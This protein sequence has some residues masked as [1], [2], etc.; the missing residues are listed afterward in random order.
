MARHSGTFSVTGRRGSMDD[1]N[2][3]RSDIVTILRRTG[4]MLLVL[5]WFV[6]QAYAPGTMPSVGLDGLSA[7]LCSGLDSGSSDGGDAGTCDWAVAHGSV[8]LPPAPDVPH[9]DVLARNAITDG[10]TAIVAIVVSTTLP[11][12]RAPP[13]PV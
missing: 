3:L 1:M 5:P 12:V 11:P 8:A 2:R 10:R 4:L 7:V 9:H 6:V 13:L